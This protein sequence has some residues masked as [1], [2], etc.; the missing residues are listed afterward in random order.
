MRQVPSGVGID[1]TG[2]GVCP[3]QVCD[4]GGGCFDLCAKAGDGCIVP[5]PFDRFRKRLPDILEAREEV[6]GRPG[7]GV[8]LEEGGEAMRGVWV[9][10]LTAEA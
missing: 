3:D 2:P 5:V 10:G 9:R 8:R 1:E 4:V 7:T 6:A